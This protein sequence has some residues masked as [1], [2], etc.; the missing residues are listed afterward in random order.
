[1][2][3]SLAREHSPAFGRNQSQSVTTQQLNNLTKLP[4][5]Q[6]EIFS[7]SGK[8]VIQRKT[9]VKKAGKRAKRTTGKESLGDVLA[10][11]LKNKGTVKVADAAKMTI[12][13]GYKTRS[14]QF[15]NIVSATLAN[16][17]RFSKVRRGQFKAK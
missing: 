9:R 6:L 5:K 12:A 2:P 1:M 7:S 14:K 10:R 4:L 8:L 15:A 16:D 11:A 3:R 13:A 17:D